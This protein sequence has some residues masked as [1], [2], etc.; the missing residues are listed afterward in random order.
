LCLGSRTFEKITKCNFSSG[1]NWKLS[2][3]LSIFLGG[4]GVDRFYLGYIGWGFFK[5]LSLGGI[6]IWTIIDAILILVGYLTPS[7]GSL[8]ED[9]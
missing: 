9:L 4:F 7:D 5:L 6:G 1:Y 8:F 2:V 3:L